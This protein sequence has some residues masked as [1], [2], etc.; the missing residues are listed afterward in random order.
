MTIS[1]AV[2][3][4]HCQRWILESLCIAHIWDGD[5]TVETLSSLL[6][7][8]PHYTAKYLGELKEL[9]LVSI[10]ARTSGDRWRPRVS[11]YKVAEKFPKVAAALAD[12]AAIQA[13]AS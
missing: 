2:G 11:G 5:I 10:I 3:L 8:S 9:K 6:G 7:H 1:P 4:T 13:E 12:K